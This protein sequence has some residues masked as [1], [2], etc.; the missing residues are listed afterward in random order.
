MDFKIFNEL[1]DR[2]LKLTKDVLKKKG[3]EYA[4]KDALFNFKRGAGITGTTPAKVLLGYLTKHLVSVLDIIDGK[5]NTESVVDEKI[6]DCINYF[7]LLEAILAEE[8]WNEASD[9][10]DKEIKLKGS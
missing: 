10:V 9:N 5:N 4:T 1:V 7:I 6:G 3:D 2:R 8:R